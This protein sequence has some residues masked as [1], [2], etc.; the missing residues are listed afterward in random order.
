MRGFLT[1]IILRRMERLAL[2]TILGMA[3][4]TTSAVATSGL[5][6]PELGEAELAV[7]K[8]QVVLGF[9][10]CGAPDAQTTAQCEKELRNALQALARAR[11]AIL[12]VATAAD[13][14]VTNQ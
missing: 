5:Q 4:V 12:G 8:A 7:E 2:G 9:A 10:V 3:I 1:R 14:G 11:S 6:D 13:R